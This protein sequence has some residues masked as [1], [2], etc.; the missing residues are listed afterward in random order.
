MESVTLLP[1]TSILNPITNYE[2]ESQIEDD[3]RNIFI[4]KPQYL[5]VM[6]NDLEEIMTYK[7][8]STQ[9]VSRTLKKGDNIRLY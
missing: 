2:Y 9:Y 8:G 6:F 1:S 7:K 4:L 5:N 3:K